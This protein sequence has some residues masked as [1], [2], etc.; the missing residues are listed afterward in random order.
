MLQRAGLDGVMERQERQTCLSAVGKRPHNSCKLPINRNNRPQPAARTSSPNLCLR[1]ATVRS[2]PLALPTP[3]QSHS[4]RRHSRHPSPELQTRA[5]GH[6]TNPRCQSPKPK[7]CLSFYTALRPRFRQPYRGP[8]NTL[9]GPLSHAF[10][11]HHPTHTAL[12]ILTTPPHLPPRPRPLARGCATGPPRLYPPLVQAFL[13]LHSSTP[14]HPEARKPTQLHIR[15]PRICCH[16]QPFGRSHCQ[17]AS[18]QTGLS[19]ASPSR[20]PCS[21]SCCS[22]PAPTSSRHHKLPWPPL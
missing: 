2:T 17:G 20:R 7:P 14:H 12:L 16:A 5:A 4:Q 19:W 1:P 9:L 11:I 3:R 15:A 13:H 8:G 10:W 22:R 21:P 6:L 18:C